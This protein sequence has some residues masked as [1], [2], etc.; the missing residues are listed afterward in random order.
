M[1]RER[2]E[3]NLDV[4]TKDSMVG[5]RPYW[6]AS[7]EDS[8]VSTWISKKFNCGTTTVQDHIDVDTYNNSTLKTTSCGHKGGGR[9]VKASPNTLLTRVFFEDYM[10]FVVRV[11]AH[12][13]YVPPNIYHTKCNT[14]QAL[15]RKKN[16]IV[17]GCIEELGGH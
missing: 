16:T 13:F 11:F 9:G 17:D 5:G 1:D 4:S 6:F 2:R 7:G 14:R 10:R 12:C 3:G 8:D 15:F